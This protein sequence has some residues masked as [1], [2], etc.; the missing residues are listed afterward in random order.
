MLAEKE[1]PGNT[2]TFYLM[3]PLSFSKNEKEKALDLNPFLIA[4]QL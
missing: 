3:N 2:G 4:F 1:S